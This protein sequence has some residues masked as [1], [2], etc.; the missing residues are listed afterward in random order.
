M[1]KD[2]KPLRIAT[3]ACPW[4][5]CSG[6]LYLDYKAGRPGGPYPKCLKCSRISWPTERTQSNR[7]EEA[8]LRS[9]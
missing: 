9:R 5:G 4:P 8:P 6:D 2:G 7:I 3:A 1:K